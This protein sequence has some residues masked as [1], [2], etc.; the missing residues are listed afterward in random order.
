MH[1]Q[2][3]CQGNKYILYIPITFLNEYYNLL[4]ITH[5][6]DDLLKRSIVIT[7]SFY[8]TYYQRHTD[9]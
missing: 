4:A 6:L 9:I 3:V 5:V 2:N 7:Y 1:M 8:D